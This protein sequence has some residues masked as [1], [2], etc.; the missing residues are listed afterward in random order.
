M[1]RIKDNMQIVPNAVHGTLCAVYSSAAFLPASYLITNHERNLPVIHKVSIHP[2]TI[3]AFLQE[4]SS[5]LFHLF[6]IGKNKSRHLSCPS[7]KNWLNR[8]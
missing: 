1:P 2:T 6:A 7:I 8:F 5:L 4:I 3:R